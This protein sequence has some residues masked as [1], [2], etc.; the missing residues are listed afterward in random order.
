VHS[1][2]AIIT[3]TITTITTTTTTTTYGPSLGGDSAATRAGI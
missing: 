2:A 3:V 1:I